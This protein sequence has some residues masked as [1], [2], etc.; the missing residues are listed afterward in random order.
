MRDFLDQQIDEVHRRS[1]TALDAGL[2]PDIISLHTTTLGTA[3]QRSVEQLQQAYAHVADVL[4]NLLHQD[5]D[6]YVLTVAAN[7][8][9][10]GSWT[11]RLAHDTLAPLIRRRFEQSDKP[12]QR[13]RRTHQMSDHFPMWME[14]QIDFGEAYLRSVAEGT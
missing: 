8:A 7:Q 1:P 9:A 10:S 2:L 11:T 14:L 13:A 6:L 5:Q 12:S 4:P 3:N